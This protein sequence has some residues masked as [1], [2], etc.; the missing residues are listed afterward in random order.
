MISSLYMERLNLITNEKMMD[1][2]MGKKNEKE[3]VTDD[4]ESFLEDIRL[5]KE[6]NDRVYTYFLPKLTKEEL[7]LIEREDEDFMR[8]FRYTIGADVDKADMKASESDSKFVRGW[9]WRKTFIIENRG[10]P[11]LLA[12]ID[13]NSCSLQ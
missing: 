9:G 11:N 8:S 13:S 7:D 2:C 5:S 6:P 12:K 10:F 3:S 4:L 1:Y